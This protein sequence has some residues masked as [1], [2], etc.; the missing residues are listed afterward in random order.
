MWEEG[1]IWHVDSLNFIMNSFFSATE[2][3]ENVQSSSERSQ[4][5]EQRDGIW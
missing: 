4:E 3:K 2:G 1:S 5:G